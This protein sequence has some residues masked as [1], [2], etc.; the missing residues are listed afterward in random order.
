MRSRKGVSSKEF[1]SNPTRLSYPGTISAQGVPSGALFGTH[2]LIKKLKFIQPAGL[3]S[4]YASGAHTI[5]PGGRIISPAGI[6]TAAAI[7]PSTTLTRPFPENQSLTAYFKNYPSAGTWNGTGTSGTSGSNN[8]VSPGGSAI[9]QR[10]TSLL[11]SHPYAI[12]GTDDYFDYSGTLDTYAAAQAFSGWALMRVEATASTAFLF[13]TSIGSGAGFRLT[14]SSTTGLHLEIKTSSLGFV[15]LAVATTT[16]VLVTWRYDGANG[17]LGVN[18]PPT[19]ATF[20]KTG[21]MALLSTAM[22]ANQSA[23]SGVVWQLAEHGLIDQAWSDG[24]FNSLKT[25]INADYGLGL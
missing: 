17:G 7:G 24:N 21:D 6:A 25:R 19:G 13:G 23:G 11:G 12:F 10:G 15:N 18:G 20:A 9:P 3:A 5:V 4:A 2:E 8:L 1:V 14:Y 22:T 16:W